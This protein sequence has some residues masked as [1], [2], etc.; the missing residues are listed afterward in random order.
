MRALGEKEGG[1]QTV[2]ETPWG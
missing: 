2:T 1:K